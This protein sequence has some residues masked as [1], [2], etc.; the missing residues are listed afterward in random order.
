VPPWT[1]PPW[2]ESASTLAPTFPVNVQSSKRREQLPEL[3]P[4]PKVAAFP[5]I[6][7]Y[8]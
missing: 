3:A 4:P 5:S 7:Q 1:A 8:M 2:P 6:V